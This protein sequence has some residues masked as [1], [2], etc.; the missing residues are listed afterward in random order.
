MIARCH[1]PQNKRFGDYGGKGITVCERWRKSFATFLRD[2]GP[3]PEGMQIDRIDNTQGYKPGNCRWATPK[4]N[5]AN[6]SVTKVWT[7]HGKS[8][9]SA[10]EA[11]EV[12]HCSTAT[13]SAWCQ[14]RTAEGRY[15]PPRASCGVR[16]AT[17]QL[18]KKLGLLP[19]DF[20]AD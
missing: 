4:Q 8:Y 1:N 2:M 7:L 5:M 13:I 20:I 19:A 14:G 15:Y 17:P 11:A 16:A 9:L 6:R 18:L 10:L 12:H 3:M